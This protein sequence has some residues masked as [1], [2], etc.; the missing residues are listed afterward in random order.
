MALEWAA[1]IIG[2]K[3]YPNYTTLSPLTATAEDAEKIARQLEQYGYRTFRV[4]RL[5]GT[6]NQ[7]GES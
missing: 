5:P 3:N 4:Q 1:Q 2:I 6:S 7:K